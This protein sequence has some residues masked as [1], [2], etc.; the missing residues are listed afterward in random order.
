MVKYLIN[1]NKIKEKKL[2]KEDHKFDFK[3]NKRIKVRF[4]LLWG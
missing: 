1:L 2:S 4:F 3:S